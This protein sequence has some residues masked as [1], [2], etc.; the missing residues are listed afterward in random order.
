MLSQGFLDA[1]NLLWNSRQHAL[2]QSVE[3]VKTAPC[4][5]LAKSHKDASHCLHV[6]RKIHWC[7]TVILA[8]AQA[9][10]TEKSTLYNAPK[11]RRSCI[12]TQV[13]HKVLKF[14]YLH[15]SITMGLQRSHKTVK[16][17]CIIFC[18]LIVMPGAVPVLYQKA[19][20]R[21]TEHCRS[22]SHSSSGWPITNCSPPFW[23]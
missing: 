18:L 20:T 2:L 10:G 4:A 11:A 13:V 5:H 23:I 9:K 17:H 15:L 21:T 16:A 22:K 12:C 7:C 8:N 14:R 19:D 6:E 1:L 3:L